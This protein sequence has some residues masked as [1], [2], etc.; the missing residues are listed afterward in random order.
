MLTDLIENIRGVQ[1]F[2]RVGVR[3]FR[4]RTQRY[5]IAQAK[6]GA[7][8]LA[9][10]GSGVAASSRVL[11]VHLL[12]LARRL[13]GT[14]A[15]VGGPPQ[16]NR[17]AHSVIDV[18]EM[19]ECCSWIVEKAQCNPAGHEVKLSTVIGICWRGGATRHLICGCCIANV[20]KLA[21]QN[22]TV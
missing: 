19:L 13:V 1:Q 2:V 14:A 12:D 20:E 4:R 16:Y 5:D 11:R 6:A 3:S 9:V 15:P 17:V 18:N 22:T 10:I 8:Q 7:C 21:N